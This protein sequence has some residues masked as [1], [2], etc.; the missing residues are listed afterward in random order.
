MPF[1]TGEKKNQMAVS[2][3]DII[4]QPGLYSRRAS[5]RE[6]DMRGDTDEKF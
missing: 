5:A 6:K 2:C 3:L 4:L 1:I